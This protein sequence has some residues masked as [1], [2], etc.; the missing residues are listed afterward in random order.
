MSRFGLAAV[1]A[2]VGTVALVSN[3]NAVPSFVRM[4]GLT[5]NQ[6]HIYYGGPDFTFTGK[7]FR[8]NGYR[9]PYVAEKIEAG[10]EG[11]LN[12]KR[13]ALG[14]QSPFSFRI[15]STLLAQSKPASQV[16][17]GATVPTL[18]SA[19]T[20]QPF[21][22]WAMF[23]VGGIG[24]HI[25]FW[26]ETYF[27]E[28]NTAGSSMYRVMGMD[29]WDLKFVFNPGYDNIVGFATTTQNHQ[30]LAGFGPSTSGAAGYNLYNG[31][32]GRGAHTPYG[33]IAAY[34]LIKDRFVVIAGV[35]SGEDNFSFQGSNFMGTL[36]LA[37]KNSD[38]N[39]LWLHFSMKAGNDAVPLVTGIALTPDVSGYVY[40]D[41][42][43]GV[44]ATR[45]NTAS[46]R[47]AYQ[48]ADMGD[49][50][51]SVYE[52]EYSFVDRGPHSF[53]SST[54]L[55][56]NKDTYADGAGYKSLGW[57]FNI[58]YMYD[59]TWGLVYSKNAYINREFTDKNGLV[60]EVTDLPVNPFA[61]TFQYRPAQNFTVNLGWAFNNT[62]GANRIAD[63]NPRVYNK[64][65]WNWSL[66]FNFLF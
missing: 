25:G 52:V 7:K 60:H 26:N 54:G 44:S 15:G 66:G 39:S 34:A 55:A 20:T 23:Y 45:G 16:V 58:H 28:G 1:V 64:D 32:A 12:G 9:T 2:L 30:Y 27:R 38:Y 41:G 19:V 46:T 3:A 50:F 10:E 4:T 40:S 21:T 65:G 18:A 51:H 6:C 33:N 56:Y 31:G 8:M 48:A 49:F 13:L 47:V 59:R 29:E 36:A 5:C 14:L 42:I 57:G 63:I 11:A 37:L 35:Q 53:W 62:G 24:D 17:G 61:A 22:N 43:T